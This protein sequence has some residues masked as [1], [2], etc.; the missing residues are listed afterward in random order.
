MYPS[1]VDFSLLICLSPLEIFVNVYLLLR[2]VLMRISL[3][4]SY[5]CESLF[6]IHLHVDRL[7]VRFTI[8]TLYLH[9]PFVLD[10]RIDSRLVPVI[11]PTMLGID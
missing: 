1:L 4:D 3:R 11:S 2:Y 8:Q 9:A 7:S 6:E 5:Y 10:L